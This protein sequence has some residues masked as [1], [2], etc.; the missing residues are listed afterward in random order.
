MTN[1][2]EVMELTKVEEG[3]VKKAINS[4]PKT[5][6]TVYIVLLVVYL[7]FSTL[8]LLD[9]QYGIMGG[10]VSLL[11]DSLNKFFGYSNSFFVY[12]LI[13]GYYIQE[14]RMLSLVKK[15]SSNNEQK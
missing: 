9:K 13:I 3:I 10:Y 5:R 7:V 4:N 6:K 1:S 14:S 8:V 12:M 11:A 15:L 2:P